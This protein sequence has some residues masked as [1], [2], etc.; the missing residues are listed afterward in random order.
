VFGAKSLID[1][2]NQAKYAFDA[3]EIVTRDNRNEFQSKMEKEREENVPSN[4]A[5]TGINTSDC[6]ISDQELVELS[7]GDMNK[8][9]KG[10][11]DEKDLRK[12]RKALKRKL[13]IIK[14]RSEQKEAME[15]KRRLEEKTERTT[16][17]KPRYRTK[18]SVKY[19]EKFE[20]LLELWENDPESI[21]IVNDNGVCFKEEFAIGSGSNGTEVYIC[22]GSD[23]IERAIKRLPKQLCKKF[24]ENE[25]DILNSRN[26]VE[27][28]R[29]VNYCFYDDTSN[30][31]FGYL[32]LSLYEQ[33]L[34][35]FIKEEGERM[36]ESRARKMIRQVLE[37]L[38][39]LHAREPRI[40]HRDLKPTNI[41]VDVGGNLLLSDFGIGRFFP[42]QGIFTRYIFN[43]YIFIGLS[44]Y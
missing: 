22:L 16:A 14:T 38:K 10:R 24:L 6:D 18:V 35:E 1:N 7:Q 13:S 27:S 17:L 44:Y 30:P 21:T 3:R 23:R 34:E 8:H 41:L 28:P 42:E 19:R 31:D 25:R 26:A 9:V 4:A 15:L 12:R 37:G 40:L 36:T 29:I 2:R 20:R 33:N 43:I 11:S 39:A 32:I 5:I